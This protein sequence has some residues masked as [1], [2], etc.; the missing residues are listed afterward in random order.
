M[1]DTQCVNTQNMDMHD[2]CSVRILIK[3]MAKSVNATVASK[4]DVKNELL[5]VNCCL[6]TN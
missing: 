5:K 1:S 2:K 3:L 4:L 6:F